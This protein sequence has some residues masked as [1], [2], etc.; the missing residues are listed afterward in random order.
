VSEQDLQAHPQHRLPHHVSVAITTPD[1]IPINGK[2]MVRQM[3]LAGIGL[4]AGAACQSGK[5]TPSPILQAMGYGDAI[6]QSGVRLTL[7]RETTA[8]DI[9][10][11]ATVFQQVLSR[12][13]TQPV[14]MNR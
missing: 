4:S 13:Q 10:W 1:G 14:L 2:A 8:A 5:V 6:A 11:T 12:L 3:N 9:D 7:G